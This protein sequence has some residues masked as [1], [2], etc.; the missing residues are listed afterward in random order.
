MFAASPSQYLTLKGVGLSQLA[1]NE[2]T[3]DV[4]DS[5][6][7]FGWHWSHSMDVLF[8]QNHLIFI[9]FMTIVANLVTQSVAADYMLG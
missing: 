3:K 6:R 4:P 5:F 1:K 7:V 8:L 2:S 9:F